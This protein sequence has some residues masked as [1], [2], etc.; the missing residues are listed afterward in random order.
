MLLGIERAVVEDVR[1]EL[2]AVVVSVRPNAREKHRC[3][4]CARRCPRE[5]WAPRYF[6][7]VMAMSSLPTVR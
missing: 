5:D 3:G 4:V 1:V 7:W 6:V 2:E